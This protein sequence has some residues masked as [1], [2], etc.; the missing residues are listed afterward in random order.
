MPN[1]GAENSK[2][3][4]KSKKE[5][6]KSK[7]RVAVG[8]GLRWRAAAHMQK[9]S[10]LCPGFWCRFSFLLAGRLPLVQKAGCS[11]PGLRLGLVHVQLPAVYA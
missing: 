2:K 4:R 3:K 10:V 1:A 7:G 8:R 5:Q 11:M 6:S 9:R